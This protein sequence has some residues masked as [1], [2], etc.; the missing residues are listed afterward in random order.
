[1]ESTTASDLTVTG[2]IVGAEVSEIVTKF[3][4]LHKVIQG[5]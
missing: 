1:M 5:V 3:M 2:Q 4:T